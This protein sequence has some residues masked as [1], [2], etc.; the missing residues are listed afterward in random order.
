MGRIRYGNRGDEAGG[1]GELLADALRKEEPKGR[2]QKEDRQTEGEGESR[3]GTRD[4]WEHGRRG[5]WL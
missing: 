4:R 1:E 2:G 5:T 3:G